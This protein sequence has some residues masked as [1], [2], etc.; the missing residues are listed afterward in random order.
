MAVLVKS[1]SISLVLRNKRY[2][3]YKKQSSVRR[4]FTESSLTALKFLIKIRTLYVRVIKMN[5]ASKQDFQ[6]SFGIILL[7]LLLFLPASTSKGKITAPQCPRGWHKQGN[8][9]Y[10]VYSAVFSRSRSNANKVCQASRAS[11]VSITSSGEQA[12][13]STLM[14]KNSEGSYGFWIGL[15]R[16]SN[17]A[18]S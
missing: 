11:L 8:D 14:K 17:S 10:K 15:K 18:F 7:L 13:V 1:R 12:L 2:S 4:I 5:V 3:L 16:S 9:C 6:L